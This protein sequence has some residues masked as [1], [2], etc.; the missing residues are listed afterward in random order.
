MQV[1]LLSSDDQ[2]F[3]VSEEVAFESETVKNMIEGMHPVSFALA[4]QVGKT[5][6]G[7]RWLMVGSPA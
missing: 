4:V 5:K 3:E 7:L 6:Q 2:S 1:K